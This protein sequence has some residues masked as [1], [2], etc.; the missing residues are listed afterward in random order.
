MQLDLVAKVLILLAVAN[1][2]PIVAKKVLGGA[3]AHPLDGGWTLSNGQPLFGSSN[4]IRGIVV[5][6]IASMLVALLLGIPWTTG[7]LVGATAMA[8][9][10]VSSFLKR[11]MGMAPSSRA[12]GLDHGFESL[13]P[14][15]AAMAE[16]NMTLLD[17]L[18]ITALF[19]AGGQV[20][21]VL[22]FKMRLRD[23]PH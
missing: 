4:T 21:S 22:L 8:G 15:L 6:V 5:A 12:F 23:H 18:A 14:A 9:D 19:T 7:L 16:L 11:R 13:F 3:F 10:L 2:A 1:G 20:L 17:V